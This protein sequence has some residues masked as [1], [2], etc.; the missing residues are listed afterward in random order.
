MRLLVVD[1]DRE[2]V[3]LLVDA[4]KLYHVEQADCAFSGE[5]ALASAIRT[6]YDLIMLDIRMPGITGL[7][8]LSIIRNLCPHAVIAIIS[9]YVTDT[10]GSDSLSGY[11][12]LFLPKPVSIRTFMKLMELTGRFIKIRGHIQEL[13]QRSK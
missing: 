11:A 6:T 1:D 2:V 13:D 10:V 4:A 12:D 8:I 9:G 7:E 3:E 5:E